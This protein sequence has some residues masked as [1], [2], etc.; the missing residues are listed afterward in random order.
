MEEK[1]LI[2]DDLEDSREPALPIL[3]S[4]QETDKLRDAVSYLEHVKRCM[5]VCRNIL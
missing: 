5:S 3:H 4:L 2:E 1:G